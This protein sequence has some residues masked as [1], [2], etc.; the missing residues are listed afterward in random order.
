MHGS[1]K[2]STKALMPTMAGS[3]NTPRHVAIKPHSTSAKKGKVTWKTDS[4]R[5]LC[6]KVG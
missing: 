2:N 3:G 1:A 5:V 4:T 6:A